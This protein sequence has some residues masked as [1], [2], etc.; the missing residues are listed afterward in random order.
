MNQTLPATRNAGRQ[1]NRY[2]TRM[3]M[4]RWLFPVSLM[5]LFFVCC[6]HQSYG[7]TYL[8]QGFETEFVGGNGVG[9]APP[10][11]TTDG[12]V[13]SNS[14]WTQQRLTT[15]NGIQTYSSSGS[16]VTPVTTEPSTGGSAKDWMRSVGTGTS[17]WT[18]YTGPYATAPTVPYNTSYVPNVASAGGIT[19]S[20]TDAT[21]SVA[22]FN[23]GNATPSGG[24][25]RQLTSPSINTSVNPG[26]GSQLLLSFKYLYYYS[27][28]ATT[29]VVIS[30][31]GGTTWADLQVLAQVISTGPVDF[32]TLSI[33]IPSKYRSANMKIGFRVLNTYGSSDIFL[34]D[35]TVKEFTPP[36]VFTVAANAGGTSTSN[37]RWSSTCTWVGGVVPGPLDSVEVPAGANL[38]IDQNVYVKGIS[39]S[40]SLL[41][42][43]GAIRV[44]CVGNLTINN[45]GTV[46]LTP[47]ALSAVGCATSATAGTS[48][49]YINLFNV[50]VASGGTFKLSGSTITPT[51]G[52]LGQIT[53]RGTITSGGSGTI[54][55][56]LR[57]NLDNSGTGSF[58]ISGTSPLN[59]STSTTV[60]FIGYSP[61]TVSG[62]TITVFS[63][64]MLNPTGVTSSAQITL[65]NGTTSGTPTFTRGVLTFTGSA[66]LFVNNTSY[67]NANTISSLSWVNGPVQY[68][69]GTARTTATF[70]LGDA[71][72]SRPLI[73]GS[74]AFTG[75]ISTSTIQASIDAITKSATTVNSPLTGGLGIRAYKVTTSSL[76]YSSTAAVTLQA[77]ISDDI[78]AF[79]GLY[80]QVRI[81]QATAA[82]TGPYTTRGNANTTVT[83]L[84]TANSTVVSSPTLPTGGG[85]S[86]FDNS[87]ATSWFTFATTAVPASITSTLADNPNTSD[88]SQGALN[89]DILRATITTGT[90]N[91][92]SYTL[93]GA[94]VASNNAND[95]DITNVKLWS[96]TSST[97]TVGTATQISTGTVT[98]SGGVATFT[99]LNYTIPS[100]GTTSY[101]YVTY[102]ISSSSTGASIGAQLNAGALSITAVNSASAPGTQPATTGTTPATRAV[103]LPAPFNSQTATRALTSTVSPG[104]TDNQI[105]G[106]TVNIGTGGSINLTAL[107]FN[108]SAGFRASTS[109][110]TDIATAKVYYTNTSN[111]FSNAT[112]FGTVTAPNGQFT[113]NGTAALNGGSDNYFWL[114]YD[115]NNSAANYDVVNA[116]LV[117][118][119]VNGTTQTYSGTQ[120]DGYRQVYA[121]SANYTEPFEVAFT[122]T[123][124]NALSANGFQS[125]SISSTSTNYGFQQATS[126]S[127]TGSSGG[128][129]PGAR[130]GSGIGWIYNWLISSGNVSDFASP[131]LDFYPVMVAQPTLHFRCTA[132][133]HH[134]LHCLYM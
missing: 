12:S 80:T 28:S 95:A 72:N 18:S 17:T 62:N 123:N 42:N 8:F 106:V 84:P 16:A 103:V 31:D 77:G 15:V 96:S 110:T 88:A 133:Q 73:F 61:Q 115:I 100:A 124:P 87:S 58:T 44:A 41:L 19:G 97:F 65:G 118:S 109:P 30:T 45:G 108:T 71:T 29:T 119:V 69:A 102:D 114:V 82:N 22:W 105:I 101:L 53:N 48:T 128:A 37:G 81:A 129:F 11:S 63:S 70:P 91:L 13:P 40:G 121:A 9:Y 57:G 107:T 76:N 23:D 10:A 51:I 85:S 74:S 75:G 134:L 14:A 60:R 35:V 34:D 20:T 92:G 130:T 83:A 3:P 21:K 5:L 132:M 66:L 56:N 25:Y 94:T 117:S 120:P 127:Y 46:D 2:A 131:K 24:L 43:A 50:L 126:A 52:L 36:T 1:G 33:V 89:V 122:G 59:T 38:V 27:G 125:S 116:T 90:G 93:T 32:P 7:Q 98:F 111:T 49:P 78:P 79:Q 6:I 55:V 67:A 104:S 64:T 68:L 112:L 47:V 26:G 99:G 113:V 54:T 86:A 39:V 4:A